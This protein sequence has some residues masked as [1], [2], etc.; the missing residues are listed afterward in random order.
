MVSQS[1]P[2]VLRYSLSI[3]SNEDQPAL[4]NGFVLRR[5]LQFLAALLH[6]PLGPKSASL[7][8]RLAYR[9]GCFSPFLALLLG[10][11]LLIRRLL[12]LGTVLHQALINNYFQ[13]RQSLKA[14][15]VFIVLPGKSGQLDWLGFRREKLAL[16]S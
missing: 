6:L 12:G 4:N 16:L 5:L 10:L 14:G 3:R 11:S 1:K 2:A 15:G 9:R 7:L 8:F 13:L